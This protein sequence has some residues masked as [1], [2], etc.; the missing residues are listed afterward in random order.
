M[1]YSIIIH[2]GAGRGDKHTFHEIEKTLG[3]TRLESMHHEALRECI[4]VGESILQQ[5]GT[6]IDAV[7]KCIKY[8]E[9]NELFNAGKGSVRNIDREYYLESSITEGKDYNFG[10]TCFINNVKNPIELSR[11]FMLD[12]SLMIA[13]NAASLDYSRTYGIETVEPSY[14]QSMYRDTLSKLNEDLGTVGAV[15]IDNMGLICA[16]TSTGGR[17]NKM[18]GRI[19]DAPLIGISTVADNEH[20]G[21]SCTGAGEEIVKGKVASQILFRMKWNNED[22]TDAI[23]RT[24]HT[25]NG[26]C[27]I[28]GVD[29][30]YRTYF[31]SNT[32]RMYV[33]YTRHDTCIST[34]L[35]K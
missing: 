14:Y 1:K 35:W 2:G 6:S 20:V 11:A 24:L 13:G 7:T 34:H 12:S 26:P 19:G 4:T 23:E 27:G 5:N 31:Q 32:E 18:R 25:V 16:G 9:D 10:S 30:E 17:Q 21:I 15:A 22:L 8:L 3:I 28:I 33:G 29:K